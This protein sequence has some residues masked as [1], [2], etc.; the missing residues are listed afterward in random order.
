MGRTGLAGVIERAGREFD[1]GS[2]PVRATA[3]VVAVIALGTLDVATGPD[4]AF[5]AFYLLPVSLAA[6][7][8]NRAVALGTCVLAAVTWAVADVLAG[9]DYS[10]W[11]INVWNGTSRLVMFV[12]V[13]VLL[14]SL[15]EALDRAEALS[16]TDALTGAASPRHFL[17]LAERERLR[18]RRTGEAI[19][20]VYIDLDNFKAV[21]DGSGHLAGDELLREVAVVL[22]GNVR[23]TDVV[24][25]MGGDEFAV[26]LPST[27]AVAAEA[28]AQKLQCA[29][30]AVFEPRYGGVSAS[31]GV[32]SFA[33]VPATF[34]DLL[35]TADHLMYEVKAGGKDAIRAVAVA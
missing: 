13:V 14:G 9:A 34:D 33:T 3:L 15:R 10:S 5:A 4:V 25:R 20:V 27:N 35:A 31:I 26:L 18:A 1:Q 24:G 28:V 7:C 6:C 22:M 29:L 19:S 30:R 23:Q 17:E 16:R 2:L 11:V 32:A 12:V 8:G 21:N